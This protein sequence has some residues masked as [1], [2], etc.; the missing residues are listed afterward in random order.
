[1]MSVDNADVTS[2]EE[3]V[4]FTQSDPLMSVD[5]ADVTSDE[6]FVPLTQSD[7]LSRKREITI[8]Y[9]QTESNK[10][11]K[12]NDHKE[13]EIVSKVQPEKTNQPTF[14]FENCKIKF[15]FTK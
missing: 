3:F 13:I 9:G 2:D 7:P 14:K 15:R 6:E 4:P 10:R 5:N 11:R 1:L 8:N 12:K